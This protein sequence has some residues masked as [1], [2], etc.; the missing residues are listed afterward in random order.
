MVDDI[1]FKFKAGRAQRCRLFL[2]PIARSRPV[3]CRR[4]ALRSA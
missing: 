2:L 1:G 3:C 4:T